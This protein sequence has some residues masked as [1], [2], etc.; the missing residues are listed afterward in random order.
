MA[1]EYEV[2]KLAKPLCGFTEFAP[3][4]SVYAA[5]KTAVTETNHLPKHLIES[6]YPMLGSFLS[7]M[8]SAGTA[9]DIKI[10]L[11]QNFEFIKRLFFDHAKSESLLILKS[12]LTDVTIENTDLFSILNTMSGGF[13][14]DETTFMDN[15]RVKIEDFTKHSVVLKIKDEWLRISSIGTPAEWAINSGIPARYVFN[16]HPD[17]AD[18]LKAIEHPETF[19]ATKLSDI[20]EALKEIKAV[21]IAD[22]QKALITEIVPS[23]YKKFEIGLAHLLEF[24][25]NKYGIQPNNWPSRPDISEFIKN[26]YKGTFA[27]QIK[28][29][30]RDKNAEEIK[31][32]LLLLADD[33]PELGLLFWEE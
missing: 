21:S 28:E 1:C 10:A 31:Q 6:L 13:G 9:Q 20:L 32:K 30:I 17:A 2:I 12:R 16:N 19:A 33:N 27:P 23:R 15:L 11:Q 25:H 7:A 24:L 22:C 18:L 5:L 8:Q 29:K 3:Y 14:L 4:E 26:Q